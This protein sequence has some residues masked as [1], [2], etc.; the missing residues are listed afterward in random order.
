MLRCQA[1]LQ[2]NSDGTYTVEVW[3]PDL[4]GVTETYTVKAIADNYAA[5]EAI[6]RFIAEHG[7]LM[8]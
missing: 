5:Q 8:G 4:S 3:S 2:E 7:T 1:A 6:E